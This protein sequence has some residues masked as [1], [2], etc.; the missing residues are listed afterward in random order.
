[1]CGSEVKYLK[2]HEESQKHKKFMETFM[3]PENPLLKKLSKVLKS[4]EL[5]PSAREVAL[6]EEQRLGLARLSYPA[7]L[8][9]LRDT[10]DPHRPISLLFEGLGRGAESKWIDQLQRA[11]GIAQAMVAK[12]LRKIVLMDGHGRFV[13]ALLDALLSLEQNLAEYTISL[14]DLDPDATNWHVEFIPGTHVH[15]DILDLEPK[16][17]TFYY[18]NFCSLGHQKRRAL[19][20]MALAPKPLMVSFFLRNPIGKIAVENGRL[21]PPK[22]NRKNKDGSLS[23]VGMITEMQQLNYD[24]FSSRGHFVTLVV[25]N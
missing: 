3:S 11:G 8:E 7:W 14:V 22:G 17:D 4:P 6:L 12:Q 2:K 18:L 15:C 24:V 20:F 19:E 23:F 1:V 9:A 10:K 16:E 13:F 21:T 5:I 25:G